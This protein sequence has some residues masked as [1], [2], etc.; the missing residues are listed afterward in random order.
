MLR[1]RRFWRAF[2]AALAASRPQRKEHTS[3]YAIDQMTAFADAVGA[4][5][6]PIVELR[7]VNTAS[8]DFDRARQALADFAAKMRGPVIPRA[9]AERL[10][11]D[12]TRIDGGRA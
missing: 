11:A 8:A 6:A 5:M 4:V 12:W 7:C 10:R 2:R 9:V 3:K 1:I